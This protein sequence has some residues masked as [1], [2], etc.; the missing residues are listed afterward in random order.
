MLS[1]RFATASNGK[2]KGFAQVEFT[3]PEAA[4]KVSYLLEYFYTLMFW[5]WKLYWLTVVLPFRPLDFLVGAGRA[6]KIDVARERA[7]CSNSD[8]V[9][10]IL[11]FEYWSEWIIVYP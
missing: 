4:M 11:N 5:P 3:T 10:I 7:S 9:I 1:I 2:F 6:L 8:I